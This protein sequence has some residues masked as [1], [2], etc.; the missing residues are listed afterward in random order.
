MLG[1]DIGGTFTDGIFV[2]EEGELVIEKSPSTDEVPSEGMFDCIEL[3]AEGTN[4]SLEYFVEGLTKFTYGTTIATNTLVERNGSE[5][6]IITTKGFRDTVLISRIGRD[7]LGQDI[8][9]QRPTPIVERRR[10]KEVTERVDTDGEIITPLDKTAAQERI[11]ELVEDGC[12]AIAL[13]LLWSFRNPKHEKELKAYIREEYPD[14]FVSR[15]SAVASVQG[16]YER[17]AT[18]MINTYLGPR[19]E[20]HLS[21]ISQDF[22][23]LGL[24][25]PPLIMQS[26]GGLMQPNEAA[27]K[28]VLTLDSGPAGAV[29]ASKAIGERVG[30]ENL[31]NIDMGGTSLDA[32]LITDGEYVTNREDRAGGHDLLIPKVEIQTVGAGGGSIAWLD[33]GR[34][35]VGPKSAGANPGPV[36]YGQ[37]GTDPT[38]TDADLL[39]G[40]INP[41]YFVGGRIALD[42]DQARA[43]M[44]EKIADS[45]GLPV[46]QAAAGVR[47]IVDAKMADALRLITI[48]RGRDPRDYALVACGG[49]GPMHAVSLASELGVDRVIVPYTASVHSALGI[50]STNIKQR[51][52][53]TEQVPLDDVDSIN[54]S[55]KNLRES[56]EEFLESQNIDESDRSYRY[57]AELRYKGQSHEVTVEILDL[58]L[59]AESPE[60]IRKRFENEYRSRYGPG[61]TSEGSDIEVVTLD[62]DAIGATNSPELVAQS[63]TDEIPSVAEKDTR[64]AYFDE[65]GWTSTTVYDGD[66]LLPGNEIRGPAILER[67]GTTI[68]IHPGNIAS[69]DQYQNTI[70][71][72]NTK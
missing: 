54:N 67:K 2:N 48:E 15:S 41:D 4:F 39:L 29:I 13:C 14:V 32:S 60:K 53:E 44:E 61:S 6:G 1:I 19:L 63:L 38:V 66:Q 7:K 70:I 9:F 20:Q 56:G 45:L 12:E 22:A 51:F 5:T 25:T 62:V 3:L 52:S 42:V 36:C 30:E 72:R 18:T 35:K 16:E 26:S 47:E 11:D 34:L 50:L 21:Q 24:T 55:L 65:V 43:V 33:E 58:P 17:S 71:E 59:T 23:D 68:V 46:E 8:R 49:A 31:I 27:R 64:E 37:G 57:Y 40:F 10:I 69:I 28:P